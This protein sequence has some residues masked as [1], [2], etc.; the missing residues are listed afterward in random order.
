MRCG[1]SW[2]DRDRWIWWSRPSG[3]RQRLSLLG[4]FQCVVDLDSEVP[5]RA[6]SE[7]DILFV[8]TEEFMTRKPSSFDESWQRE[9]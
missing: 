9:R 3:V 8:G 6:L 2:P 4:N 7:D 1:C 5:D